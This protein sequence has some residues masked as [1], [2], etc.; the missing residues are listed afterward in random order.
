MGLL[1]DDVLG[2]LAVSASPF[3]EEDFSADGGAATASLTSSALVCG[4]EAF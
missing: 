4:L 1:P 2:A 3:I